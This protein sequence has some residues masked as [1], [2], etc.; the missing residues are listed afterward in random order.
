MRAYIM[1]ELTMSLMKRHQLEQQVN[2]SHVPFKVRLALQLWR[3]HS[4][5]YIRN[6]FSGKRNNQGLGCLCQ[7][8]G[9]YTYVCFQPD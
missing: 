2:K 4:I 9:Q 5:D 8:F 1:R 3:F 6:S 7:A